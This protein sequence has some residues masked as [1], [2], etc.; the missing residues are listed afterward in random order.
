M[1]LFR[2]IPSAALLILAVGLV[3]CVSSQPKLAEVKGRVT[4]KGKAVPCGMVVF[5]EE[6]G[7]QR[8]VG[9]IDSSGNYSLK[10]PLGKVKAAVVTRPATSDSVKDPNRPAV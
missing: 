5:Q 10:A 3:G 4:Y 7:N 2:R 1:T 8:G 9:P 6:N